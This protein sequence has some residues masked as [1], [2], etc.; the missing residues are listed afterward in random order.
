MKS[1]L[2][3]A[4]R[5][6]RRRPGFAALAVVPLAIGIAFTTAIF[7]IAS[8]LLI[9]PLPFSDGDRLMFLQSTQAAGSI[10]EFNVAALDFA[11]WNRE[12]R[13]FSS[14]GASLPSSLNMTDAGRAQRVGGGRATA[15]L[16]GTLGVRARLGRVIS[17]DDERT[18]APV[19]LLS[20]EFWQTQFGGSPGAIGRSISLDGR[21]YSVVGVLPAGFRFG[22]KADVF[23]PFVP[24]GLELL[25][26]MRG[27]LVVGR[28]RPGIGRA[29]AES[30]VR[31]ISATLARTYR[32]DEGWGVSVRPLRDILVEGVRGAVWILVAASGF[33]LLVAC[34]NVSNLLLIRAVDRRPEAALR[35]AL[36]AG[37]GQILRGFVAESLL[38]GAAGG[39]LGV[40]LAWA[41][42]KPLLAVCPVELSTVGPV[43]IDARVLAFSAS[44]SILCALL[45][46]SAA[47][48][49]GSRTNLASILN[50]AGRA[51]SGGRG[52]RRIQAALVA[53]EIGVVFLLM[54]GS[55]VALLA[56]R[57]LTEVS[58]GFETRGALTMPIAIPDARY[59]ELGQREA[60]VE[61]LRSRLAA[62]P[63]IT[64]VA[65]TNKLPL[66]ENYG[67]TS[68]LAEGR[69]G[70][71]DDAGW[72]AHFRRVSP[73]YF[74]T[75]GTPLVEGREF[76]DDDRDGRPLVAIV[77][78]ELA[79]RQWP[80][81]S[82]LGKRL[83]RLGGSRPWITV[84]GVAGDVHDV[85][86]AK[87]PPSTLY[88][89]YAQGKAGLPDIAVVVRTALPPSALGR[90]LRETL[91]AIDPDLPSGAPQP[92][93]FLVSDSLKRQRFQMLL[94]GLLAA[95][96]TILASA[97]IFG[98]TAYTVSQ[99]SREF[100]IR[101]ALGSTASGVVGLVLRRGAR[102]ASLGLLG[103]LVAVFFAR[104]IL[105]GMLPGAPS[106]GP[107]LVA[108]LGAS[109]GAVCMLASWLAARR[110]ARISPTF[111]TSAR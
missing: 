41:G 43:G 76:S 86:L 109:F 7:S 61:Q 3:S 25:R 79:R 96:G 20:S 34:V 10:Q 66:D 64:S 39:A 102:L 59:P 1:D 99:Q 48:W 22:P 88:V 108:G 94:M 11:D 69:P 92:L 42:L 57:R 93:S 5:G 28:L 58:P 60:L 9:R 40:A 77:S 56:F 16:F 13:S 70:P 31:A 51:A 78:R 82:A 2:L 32:E 104:G 12:N 24:R 45:F 106:P 4:W 38:L 100:S 72:D 37:R 67:L 101:L 46:G 95:A 49:E 83:Q 89:P 68:F 52:S 18:N 14:M 85:S 63:G 26:N 98:L 33:L 44:I 90:P 47:G 6:L 36:G 111:A 105:A 84:V 35:A 54:T 8:A 55:A 21:S 19:V 107:S 87:D 73:A 81:Q 91:A 110:A 103:G 71:P 30:D 74:Q 65:T 62:I 17:E 50:D 27:L 53:S 80:G 15:G 97:G 29:Q 23:L 75:M